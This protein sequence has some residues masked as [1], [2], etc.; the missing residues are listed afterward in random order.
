MGVYNYNNVNYDVYEDKSYINYFDTDT[1]I[2]VG[3][4]VKFGGDVQFG[5]SSMGMYTV[6]ILSGLIDR[7]E[8]YTNNS[9][10]FLL[11]KETYK[12]SNN[13]THTISKLINFGGYV[14]EKDKQ[15]DIKHLTQ[16]YCGTLVKVEG[17]IYNHSV[18]SITVKNLKL[19]K[20]TEYAGDN[21]STVGT[22][23]E[24]REGVPPEEEIRAGRVFY[25]L[26]GG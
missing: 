7:I 24:V 18:H 1:I 4:C 16:M 5:Y 14:T 25:D 8:N 13:E 11:L 21:S 23:I 3:T 10:I 20:S 26:L 12:N 19:F 6:S 9:K 2:P 15:L 17:A 22:Y